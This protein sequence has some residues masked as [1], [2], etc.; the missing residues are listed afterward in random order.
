MCIF[1]TRAMDLPCSAITDR[2]ARSLQTRYMI[3]SNGAVVT[4]TKFE[5]AVAD[6]VGNEEDGK[7]KRQRIR[8]A[9]FNRPR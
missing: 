9:T 8:Y 6:S 1:R 5:S 3:S 7:T 2:P 4:Y